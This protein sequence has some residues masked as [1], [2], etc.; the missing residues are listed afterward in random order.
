MI[1]FFR[2]LKKIII[3]IWIFI[4][5]GVFGFILI[6][7]WIDYPIVMTPLVFAT[8]LYLYNDHI[9]IKKKKEEIK[10]HNEVIKK[11]N[12]TRLKAKEGDANAC[13]DFGQI[14]FSE[15]NDEI[16]IDWI[17]LAASKNEPR[18]LLCM[19]E[20]YKKGLFGIPIDKIKANEFMV[21]ASQ[22]DQCDAKAIVDSQLS[23][24]NKRQALE[25]KITELSKLAW[26]EYHIFGSA[27]D[28]DLMTGLEFE[29]FVGKLYSKL[30]YRVTF[31]KNND[32]GTDVIA[33]KGDEKISIQTKRY[34]KSVGN[35]AVQETIAGASY[36]SCNK[37]AVVTNSNFTKS[38]I[39]LAKRS[40]TELIDGEKLLSLV[41]VSSNEN[42]KEF[43][44][45]D[46]FSLIKEISNFT[47]N[48]QI[49]IEN[50]ESE[51]KYIDINEGYNSDS[52]KC[53]SFEWKYKCPLKWDE[54][55]KTESDDIKNCRQCGSKVY[56]VTDKILLKKYAYEGRCTASPIKKFDSLK[57]KNS[58][59]NRRR[60]NEIELG[61]RANF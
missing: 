58:I 37:K 45:N 13:F 55:E 3:I 2:K 40:N 53:R 7:I 18:A 30:G 25:D 38:A 42:V 31:T 20:A 47:K 10:K 15:K 49:K 12:E 14:L 23:K 36:H 54:L 52:V 44:W 29:K 21:K 9:K 28:I 35:K 57:H 51:L 32:Q 33:K 22:L 6:N 16:A 19:F 56:Y 11:R 4:V 26:N 24:R 60:N 8:A 34:K 43:N 46:Y 27:V 48:I 5:F 61:M 50:T 1:S 59:K 17:K 39:E 41:R